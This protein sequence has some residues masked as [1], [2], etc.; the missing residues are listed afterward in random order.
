MTITQQSFGQTVAGEL[1]NLFTLSS[2]AGLIA[3]ITNYG[4]II[5]SILAPDRHGQ[6]VDVTLG[7]DSPASYFKKHPFFGA[8]AGRYANRIANGKFTLNGVEYSLAVNNG[9]NHLHGGLHGFDKKVWQAETIGNSLRLTCISPDGEEGYPGTLAVT[10]TYTLTDDNALHIDYT[11]TTDR[12]TVINLTNHSYFNLAGGGDI[13][14]HELTLNADYFTPVNE[15]LIPTGE[16]R[17]VS[18]TPHDFTRPTPI[19]ARINQADVQLQRAGG[20][21]DHNFVLNAA[22]DLSM[23]SARA[24]EPQSGRTL[25][26]YTT[27]PGV[28]LYT[29]N[30]FDGTLSGKGGAA[31]PKHAGFCLETQH[32]PDSPNQPDFPPTVL[33]PGQ[34]YWQSTIYKFGIL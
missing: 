25:E 3:K 11:A 27:Q 29:A 26:M 21:Y 8:L 9:P 2:E 33:N 14:G 30:A 1:V 16:L 23:L 4:G 13:L 12:P 15:N 32:Y 17:P 5:V 7:F 6:R 31:Y 18:N 22:G 24:A 19:G 34:T 10:A 20:G 28:Q